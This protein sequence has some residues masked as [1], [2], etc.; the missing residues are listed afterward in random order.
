MEDDRF[1]TLGWAR[2]L[3]AVN[4]NDEVWIVFTGLRQNGVYVQGLVDEIDVAANTVRI[5]VREHSTVQPLTDAATSG[6]L[7]A[8]VAARNRQVF[9]WPVQHQ[10]LEGCQATDCQARRC[11]ACQTWIG[12]A[13]I[14]ARHYRPPT[15]LHQVMVIP[16]YWIIPARCFLY[17]GA[18]TPA[19][20]VRRVTDMFQAFKIGE[21]RYAHPLA[22]GIDAALRARQV[23]NFDAIVPVP[24]SPEK[25]ANGE[26]NRTAA[27]AQEL[28]P[29]INAPVRQLLSLS[30]PISKRRMLLQGY[31]EAQFRARY[32]GLLQVEGLGAGPARI[33]VV[34]DVITRG[35]T[36]SVVVS[37]LRTAY[38]QAEI[39]VAA[40]GQMIV[41]AAVADVNGP[42]W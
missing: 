31:S 20:W 16:A 19:P 2:Y 14:Q 18:R 11:A 33:L 9:T 15:S 42:A 13:E 4:R 3:D 34:D 29:L 35:Y 37:I 5:R 17:Y 30:G 7:L 25:I 26:L 21:A 10:L 40:S 28:S 22:L 38:P 8:A 24:L 41:K 12:F 32:R 23:G 6:A 27:L 36:L 39:V 1:L